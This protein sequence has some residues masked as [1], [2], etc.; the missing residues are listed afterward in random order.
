[1]P[2]VFGSPEAKKIL[3]ADKKAI[4]ASQ[5]LEDE[6]MDE[7]MTVAQARQR[8]ADIRRE[9]E[10]LEDEIAELEGE[11]IDLED[12]VTRAEKLA[13]LNKGN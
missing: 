13:L 9:I 10:L 2:I 7:E 5:L 8:L 6:E 11:E 4:L 12:M 1:M 3:E